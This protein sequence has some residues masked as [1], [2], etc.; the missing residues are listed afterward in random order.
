[1]RLEATPRFRGGKGSQVLLLH[2]AWTSWRIWTPI[3]EQL[4]AERDVLAITMCGHFGGPAQPFNRENVEKQILGELDAA[5]FDRPHV[6]GN[7]IGAYLALELAKQG[8]FRSVVALAPKGKQTRA[9][10]EALARKMI[11][12][13]HFLRGSLPLIRMGIHIPAFR[14]SAMSALSAQGDR[15]PVPLCDHLLRAF[16]FTD[17]AHILKTNITE[18]GPIPHIGDASAIKCPVLFVR[19]DRDGLVERDEIARYRADIPHAELIELQNCGHS[20]QLD[21]PDLIAQEILRF[22]RQGK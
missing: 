3:L 14:K 16:A 4:A 21:Y 18:A 11:R 12:E 8:R 22:T 20:P 9:H 13:H 6:V 5:G 17:A 2:A 19:G 7:S 15:L 10:G 1:M